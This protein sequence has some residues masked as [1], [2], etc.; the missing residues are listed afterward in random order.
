VTDLDKL[1]A[2]I[3]FTARLRNREMTFHST[4]GLFSPRRVDEGS[5]LL[6]RHIDISEGDTSLDLGCGY[7]VIGLTLAKLA[8]RGEVHLVDKD[9]VAIEY[10]AKN[11]AANG[12]TNCRAYLSNGFREVP[13]MQFDNIVANL[14]AKVG[15]EL[16]WILLADANA[17]LE[18][19]GQLVV[20][21]VT[22]LRQFI[23]R[24][25]NEVFGNYTKLKQGKHYTVGRAV[26]E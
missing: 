5:A 15:K 21:T 3:V 1:K 26:K 19:G 9:F 13:E 8:P 25:F 24:N 17:H 12:L 18:A 10:A 6:L 23:K 2:D 20:V 11:I 14:P 7:G 16:L 4:W 22:G